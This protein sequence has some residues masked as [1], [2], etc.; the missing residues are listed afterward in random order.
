[1]E[2]KY[3]S[4]QNTFLKAFCLHS[5][6]PV[7]FTAPSGPVRGSA[8]SFASLFSLQS[9]CIIKL[10]ELSKKYFF[11]VHTSIKTVLKN[12]IVEKQ[13]F[14]LQNT[15]LKCSCISLPP[16][17][18]PAPKGAAVAYIFNYNDFYNYYTNPSNVIKQT[19][20]TIFILVS[21]IYLFLIF[22]LF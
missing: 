14:S 10:I 6:P 3:I 12:T 11:L 1:M 5:L 17:G 13:P 19:N 15:I 21:N 7:G 22:L 8:P 9:F 16:V 2:R 18:F 4:L 20:T